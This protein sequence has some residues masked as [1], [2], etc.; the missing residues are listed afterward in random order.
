MRKPLVAIVGRPNV[1][2]SALFNSIARARIAIVEGTP[3]VTRDRIY[4]DCEWLGKEF[5]LVDTGGIEM[6]ATESI[7]AQT[8]HQAEIAIVE[9]DVILLVVDGRQ[10]LVPADQEVADLLRKAR[11]PVIVVVNKVE[12]RS[13]EEAIAEFFALGLGTPQ[14]VSA[15]HGLQIGDLLDQVI[16]H[17]PEDQDQDY[18]EAVIKVAVIGRPNVGKSSLVNSIL[19]EERVIVSDIPGTTRDAVDTFFTRGDR[20]FVIIDTA[21]MRRKGNISDPLERYSVLRALRAVDRC[22]VA[23]MLIDATTGVTE[24]DTKIAGYAHEAGRGIIIVVNKWDLIA[25][26]EKT[27]QNYQEKVRQ[28]LAFLNYAPITFVSALTGKRVQEVVDLIEFTAEQHAT[29]IPT[30]NLN[31]VLEEAIAVNEPPA[32]KGK[33]LKIFYLTQV[34]VKPPT[35]AVFVNDSSLLH[36]SYKRFLENKLREAF[37]FQGTPLVFLVREKER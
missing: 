8:R 12:D 11:K 30:A 37:G 9:A 3:G 26:D 19:G 33:Q 24:Q 13:G 1:G 2:K 32:D 29:R 4:A 22:D 27:M 15:A 7:A 14:A 35:F 28:E 10:G 5:V 20:S 23:L 21:G 31:E 17:F 34:G 18:D 16:A 36:F 6:D 25:K